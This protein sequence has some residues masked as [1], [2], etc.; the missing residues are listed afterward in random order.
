[1]LA[2]FDLT[3]T[4]HTP[5]NHHSLGRVRMVD[6]DH[7]RS[8]LQFPRNVSRRWCWWWWR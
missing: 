2:F 1:L 6:R 8:V 4:H 3:D 5:H 7:L